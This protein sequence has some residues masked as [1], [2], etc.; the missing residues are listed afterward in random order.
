MAV[1]IFRAEFRTFS[2]LGVPGG[3]TER[4]DLGRGLLG[5]SGLWLVRSLLWQDP[6]ILHL[7]GCSTSCRAQLGN[8]LWERLML[9][10]CSAL[11]MCG[12]PV[13]NERSPGT[14]PS[15]GTGS[16]AFRGTPSCQT[17]TRGV[18]SDGTR[19]A[20]WQLCFE[21]PKRSSEISKSSKRSD[22]EQAPCSSCSNPNFS[23][24]SLSSALT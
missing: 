4:F 13:R 6:W 20:G 17:H 14:V 11:G 16:S 9:L 5:W 18:C 8:P 3:C 7:L 2:V 12:T 19:Q 22:P 1:L 15:E 24:R 23:T 21:P 10:R